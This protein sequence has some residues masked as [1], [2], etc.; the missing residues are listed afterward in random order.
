LWSGIIK[1]KGGKEKAK[2]KNGKEKKGRKE[3]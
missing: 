3:N 1:G 2:R